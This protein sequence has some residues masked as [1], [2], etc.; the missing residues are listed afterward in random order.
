MGGEA[1]REDEDKGES[2]GKQ[3]RRE[4]GGEVTRQ[5]ERGSG[6]ELEAEVRMD[7]N[8]QR[9]HTAEESDDHAQRNLPGVPQVGDAYQY[10]GG[11]CHPD[12][13]RCVSD[14]ELDRIDDDL[15]LVPEE[16]GI[17]EAVAVEGIDV[18]NVQRQMGHVKDSEQ[19][20]RGM[21]HYPPQLRPAD[22]IDERE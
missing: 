3:Q 11:R 12:W 16:Q 8:R 21:E 7:R 1:G 17:V 15:Q 18:A 4:V 5:E 2:F 13:S 20:Q 19:G 9:R 10:R 14:V 22:R 6:G